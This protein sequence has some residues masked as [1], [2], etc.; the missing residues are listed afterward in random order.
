[1]NG[2]DSGEDMSPI[3]SQHYLG[4]VGS[5]CV[6]GQELQTE[7][8]GSSVF[9]IKNKRS[10]FK[11]KDLPRW[12]IIMLAILCFASTLLE[13]WFSLLGPFFPRVAYSKGVSY[14]VIGI[15][16]ASF[17]IP[18]F[19]SS[20]V[21]G[22]LISTIGPKFMLVSGLFICAAC[23]VLFG[24]LDGS[25]PGNTFIALSIATRCVE[26][27]GYSAFYVSSRAI[28]GYVFRDNVA[29][30]YG[31]LNIF[32]GLGDMLGY[33]LGGVL[34]E[35]GGFGMPFWSVGIAMLVCTGVAFMFTPSQY[36][37][38]VTQSRSFIGL[39][40]SP[41]VC[42]ACWCQLCFAMRL[43]VVETT[44]AV[45]IEKAFG[46]SP[47][48]IGLLYLAPVSSFAIIAPVCAWIVDKKGYC[49][50]FLA[51]VPFVAAITLML[52]G[53]SPLLKPLKPSIV[54]NCVFGVVSGATLG[55]MYISTI[56]CILIGV[57]ELG[58]DDSLDTHG[59]V[60]SCYITFTTA[61][62]FS[63]A[64]F[65]GVMTQHAG[66]EWSLTVIAGLYVTCGTLALGLLLYR[67]MK[68]VTSK[69]NEDSPDI[70]LL[71]K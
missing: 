57:K 65:G 26:A 1:M 7:K 42:I 62:F 39:F 11:L 44:Y 28:V 18:M 17:E 54:M 64:V 52:W 36:G 25:P 20:P 63:G 6:H 22:S 19:I 56:G 69:K 35:L 24:F 5:S 50:L 29:M 37:S 46:F 33:P 70:L 23:S 27:L 67:Y 8:D 2:H 59:L 47:L 53:P 60:S 16:F 66:F 38:L 9:K 12:K 49:T 41:I 4:E 68:D 10:G 43:S 48:W 34:F 55:S 13:M 51:V 30:I 32:T 31:I 15:I 3:I 45:Y 14:T 71:T 21:F 40:K 61:G 58:Y